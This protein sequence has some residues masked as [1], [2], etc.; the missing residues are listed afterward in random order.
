M[1]IFIKETDKVEVIVYAWNDDESK[2]IIA[3]H[4]ENDVPSNSEAQIVKFNFRR[5]TY[6][7]SNAILGNASRTGD[8][9]GQPD[10][11]AFQDTI[12]RTLLLEVVTD[13]KTTDMRQTKINSLHPNIAR[14]AIAG[15]LEKVTI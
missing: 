13:G 1:D 14:A 2:D 7:D 3:S 9:A 4:E 11:M 8:L 6:Q 12:I 5:P 10:L 15:I